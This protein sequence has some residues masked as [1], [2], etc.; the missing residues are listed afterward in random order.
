MS[1]C[2]CC[3]P[4]GG[5]PPVAQ[6]QGEPVARVE[7]GAD[8]NAALT[9]TDENWLRS[10]KDHGAHQL[11]PLYANAGEVEQG[12]HDSVVEGLVNRQNELREERDTLRAQ[13]SSW[14]ALAAERQEMITERDALLRRITSNDHQVSL[15]A[16]GEAA[17]LSASA[18]RNQ[19]DGCQAGIPLVKGAHRMGKPGGYADTM[20]CQAGKYA[21]AEPSARGCCVPS[22]EEKALLATGEYTPQELWGGSRPTCPKCFKAEP[23]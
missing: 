22:A 11:V 14:Q 5:T 1:K 17:A 4:C 9:I 16:I 12:Y 21:S 2:T 19:C 6:H 7:I 8:R 3:S 20:S 13:L 18:E 23:K 15:K 10:L